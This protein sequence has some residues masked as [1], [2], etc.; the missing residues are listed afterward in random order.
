MLLRRPT[1]SVLPEKVGKKRRLDADR[2]V[3]QATEE[4]RKR[5]M[6]PAHGNLPTNLHYSAACVETTLPSG[7][8][9]AHGDG[10]TRCCGMQ[11]AS[12]FAPMVRI[13]NGTGGQRRP[14]KHDFGYVCRGRCPHRPLQHAVQNH[15]KPC[16]PE[17]GRTEIDAV[18]PLMC[19]VHLPEP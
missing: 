17:M 1:F 6:Q 19:V 10:K 11:N 2:I 14:P 18:C 16:I 12:T 7:A 4:P 9:A 13:L 8:V 15:N 3:P 5:T